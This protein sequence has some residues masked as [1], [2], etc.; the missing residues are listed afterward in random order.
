MQQGTH[1]EDIDYDVIVMGGGP[2]GSTVATLMAAAGRRVTL[3]ERLPET[4]FKIGESL[5]PETYRTFARLGLLDQ[6]YASPFPRKYSV[7]FY[8]KSGRPSAPF[9]FQETDPG[10]SSITW[11]VPRR[12]FDRL[13]IDNA[14]RHGVEVRQG[15]TVREVLFD[16]EQAVGVAADLPGEGRR[17]L[18]A[19]VVVD[20]TGQSA[21]LGRRLGLREI[22]PLLRKAAIFSHFEGALR[23]PGIDEGATLVLHTERQESWFWYIPLPHDR[24]S[25]GVVG[26][27]EYL[28]GGRAGNLQQVFE[29]E[30]ARCPPLVPRLAGARRVMDFLALRDFS[31][32]SR[33]IAGPGWVLVGDAFGFLDPIYSS[34]VLLAFS[35]GEFAADAILG[36][37]ADGDLSGARLG[38][39]GPRFVAG[40]DAMRVLVH[41]FYDPNFRF[42]KFIRRFPECRH[43]LIRVLR[44]D[45]F[46]HDFSRLF[47]ALAKT[48]TPDLPGGAEA[49]AGRRQEGAPAGSLQEEAVAGGAAAA[50]PAAALT[51]DRR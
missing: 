43:D 47:A 5:M 21:I 49:P 50:A 13:L 10:E 23:D 32:K 46:D 4:G 3:L 12:D 38:A 6:L 8:S 30:V 9:Y 25:V 7:Q 44:G 37:L 45:V 26:A 41:T 1:V 16:G 22:D 48:A 24:V 31:Y 28:V 35:S 15:A 18:H 51:G 33:Q 19:R 36:A 14:R 17:E 42:S 27:V 39:F 20:A 40:M 29:E 2:A 11:Q 34:G